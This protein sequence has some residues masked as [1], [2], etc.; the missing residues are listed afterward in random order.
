MKTRIWMA[1][2]LWAG[3]VCAGCGSVAPPTERL[4]TAEAA[5]RGALE[6]DANSLPRGALHLKL[7]QYLFHPVLLV[8]MVPGVCGPIA[9][10]S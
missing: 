6:V 7:A 5:I 9:T 10:D 8:A 2:V 4:T 1:A 3:A